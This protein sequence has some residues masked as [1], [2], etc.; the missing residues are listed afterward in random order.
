MSA[1][2]FELNAETRTPTTKGA[3]RRLRRDN[4]VPVVLYGAGKDPLSLTLKHNEVGKALENEAFYTRIITLKV[5]GNTTEKA[6]VKAIQ[7]HPFKLKILH[8]DFLRIHEHKKLHIRIPLHFI[9]AAVS[10][11]VKLGGGTVSHNLIDVEISCLPADIPEFI[12]VDLSKLELGESIHLSELKL[13][14]GVEIV[15]GKEQHHLPVVT[16]Q[17]PRA[18]EVT[19]EAAPEATA[20]GTAATTAAAPSDTT[21]TTTTPAGKGAAPAAG[22]KAP[23]A[24]AAKTTAPAGGKAAGAPAAAAKKGSG[25][26]K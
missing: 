26:K 15:H 18:E 4:K 23:A 21:A 20:E 19:V 14:G 2:Q 13:P 9:N 8:M 5:P 7:R 22:G 3:S 16:I 6:V 10:P 11:G 12:E 1:V 17:A 24:G 25:N